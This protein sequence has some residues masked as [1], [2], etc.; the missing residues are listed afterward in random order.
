MIW[1]Q[2]YVTQVGCSPRHTLL[3]IRRNPAL[4]LKLRARS[5]RTQVFLLKHFLVSVREVGCD[6]A[7]A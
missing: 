4:I 2:D 7:E 5:I 1:I 6:W 3:S